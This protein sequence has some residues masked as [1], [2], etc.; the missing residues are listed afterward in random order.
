MERLLEEVTFNDK[1]DHLIFTGDLISKGPDSPGVVDLARKHAASCVRGNHE[2]RVL[3]VRQELAE[4]DA[5]TDTSGDE[6]MDGLSTS[7]AQRDLQLARNLT[8][9]QAEWLDA[10]PVILNVGHIP[11]MGQV[12]VVHGGLVPGVDYDKQDPFS[13]M[14]MLTIDLDTHLPSSSRDG[15][16]WTKVCP[17]IILFPTTPPSRCWLTV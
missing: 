6:Y 17:Y 9:E 1:T 13:V 5:M 14:N 11:T 3:L 2:D 12:A 16:K 15:K 8:D 10:C 7:G 4:M